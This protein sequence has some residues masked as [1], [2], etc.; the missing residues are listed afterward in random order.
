MATVYKKFTKKDMDT[1]NTVVPP[2]L[3]SD[4]INNILNNFITYFK[5]AH[6]S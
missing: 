4:K 1:R 2:K 3:E 6:L 5:N